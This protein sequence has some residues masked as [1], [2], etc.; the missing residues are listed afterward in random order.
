MPRYYFDI[1]EGTKFIPDE[2]GEEFDSLDGAEFMA[3]RTGAEVGRGILPNRDA[4]D[5]TVEVRNEHR[6]RVLTVTLSMRIERVEPPPVAPD[7]ESQPLNPW[8]E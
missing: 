3:A 8:N 1:R 7:D 2:S 5:I 6:Q 4:R